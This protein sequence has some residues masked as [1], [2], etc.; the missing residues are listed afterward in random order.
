M[1]SAAKERLSSLSTLF[2]KPRNTMSP[3]PWSELVDPTL[4]QKTSGALIFYSTAAS[5]RDEPSDI[6]DKLRVVWIYLNKRPDAAEHEYLIVETKDGSRTRQFVI[7]RTASADRTEVARNGPTGKSTSKH[8]TA[9]GG[10]QILGSISISLQPTISPSSLSSMEE[11][12]STALTPTIPASQHSTA[13]TITMAMS[14]SAHTVSES[15]GKEIYCLAVDRILGQS[16]VSSRNYGS[17]R[18]LRNLKP[19]DLTFFELLFLAHIVHEREPQYSRLQKNCYWYANTIFE[20]VAHLFGI[21]S[22]ISDYD[23]DLEVQYSPVDPL[24]PPMDQPELCGRWSSLKTVATKPE[25]IT[26]IISTYKKS[27]REEHA[28]VRLIL[29][30]NQ[31]EPY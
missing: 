23:T 25:E 8:A 31:C 6:L 3:D 14:S 4:C 2:Y 26:D 27:Y 16:Y 18:N 13:D 10:Y 22:S 7:E 21:D 15:L 24:Q 12:S 19:R 11:G 9:G 20:T 17:S 1:L 29:F 30:S 5:N 28:K